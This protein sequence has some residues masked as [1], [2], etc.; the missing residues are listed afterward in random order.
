[1]PNIRMPDGKVVRFPDDMP[2][3]QIKSLIAS[4]FPELA[5]EGPTLAGH[6]KAFLS[7]AQQGIVGIMGA[8]GDAGEYA[9]KGIKAATGLNVPKV[10]LGPIFGAPTSEQIQGA[11]E[12]AGGPVYEP[13]KGTTEE[14]AGTAGRLAPAIATGP[15][16][17]IRKGIQTGISALGVEGVGQA[18]R[19]AAPEY[20]DLGR[21]ATAVATGGLTAAKKP[22]IKAPLAS[23]WLKSA[24]D[25]YKF[26]DESGVGLSG[27]A[28]K[29]LESSLRDV[30][31]KEGYDPDFHTGVNSFFSLVGKKVGKPEFI[32]KPGSPP[33]ANSVPFSQFQNLRS[34]AGS[35][36][37]SAADRRF[38]KPV[39]DTLDNFWANVTSKDILINGRP[40]SPEMASKAAAAAGRAKRA[41]FMGKKAELL[42]RIEKSIGNREAQY[43]VSG[44]ENALRTEMR[45]LSKRLEGDSKASKM[46]RATFTKAERARIDQMAKRLSLGGIARTIG[47]YNLGSV[48]A[49][50]TVGSAGAIGSYL[51]NGDPRPLL[52]AGAVLGVGSA[53]RGAGN[54]VARKQWQDF[55]ARAKGGVQPPRSTGQLAQPALRGAAVS[56]SRQDALKH[57]ENVVS[58]RVMDH[59]KKS[60]TTRGLL[61]DWL[62]ARHAGRGQEEATQMLASAIVKELKIDDP[63]VYDRIISELNQTQ[64]P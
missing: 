10:A 59:I 36:Y 24:K 38:A 12:S 55:S 8:A 33:Q 22:P 17:I 63:S 46:L 6:G 18:L 51:M 60:P 7:G 26:L 16:G 14:L 61:N 9:R 45:G 57:A 41:Y 43:S 58:P 29:R 35:L 31:H 53:V 20:E 34:D 15:G 44:M 2:P 5:G 3:D 54:R 30:V 56:S 21:T 25:D 62:K 49:G 52:A 4:K 40:P 42:D 47:K 32:S 23:S 64:G 13:K 37:G 50:G 48:I 11:Y 1:M 28:M 39:K 27:P 19:K